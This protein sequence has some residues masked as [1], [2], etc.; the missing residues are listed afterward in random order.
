MLQTASDE[1]L[2]LTEVLLLVATLV[3][4]VAA[5]PALIE[6]L[7]ERRKLRERLNINLEDVEVSELQP[8]LAGM[9][10]LLTSI[11]DLIDR[12]RHPEA[13]R[14][15]KIGNEVLIIGPSMSGKKSLAQRIAKE[16]CMDRLVTVYNPRDLDALGKAKGLVLQHKRHKV[17]LLLPRLDL[18]F[19]ENSYDLRTEID[20]VVESLTERENVLVVGT[21]IDFEPQSELDDIFGI[22]LLLPG[23]SLDMAPTQP[24]SEEARS[25]HMAVA[26]FYLQRALEQGFI[27]SG[28]TEDQF[29]TEVLGSATNPAE[30][31]D[32]VSLC[33]TT[34]IY[35]K[36][37]AMSDQLA[38]TPG[39]LAQAVG[40]VI[41]TMAARHS[42][43]AT[44]RKAG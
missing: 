7:S 43:K 10:P 21:V 11:A 36:R 44:G 34:A 8:R 28:I 3:G 2:L 20:A 30:I 12:A 25:V 16:A 24:V 17:M 9:D 38:I 31:E 33:Q 40:R 15:V 13:Y 35:R 42:G 39:I 23:T 41:V 37:G 5:L 6:F 29:V 19:S 27:L 4:S 18:P 22:K 1:A 32:I 26:R 14:Q